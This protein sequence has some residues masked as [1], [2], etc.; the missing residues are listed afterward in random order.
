MILFFGPHCSCPNGLMTSNMVPAR[1]HTT[2]VAVYLA[3][4]YSIYHILF[5]LSKN[6]FFTS[7]FCL[8]Q[9]FFL[10]DTLKFLF[11]S[12]FFASSIYSVLQFSSQECSNSN[13][14]GNFILLDHQ[15][16]ISLKKI[17]I[18]T[19][20]IMLSLFLLFSVLVIIFPVHQYSV[21][22]PQH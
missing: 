2:G 6:C 1:P 15:V 17:K 22:P 9:S 12:F 18:I 8:Y 10:P 3:L 11:V 20:I 7:V 19:V 14:V 16:F 13:T 5:F 21:K 4:F